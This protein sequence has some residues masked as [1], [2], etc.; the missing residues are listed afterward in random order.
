MS[1]HGITFDETMTG[2]FAMGEQEPRAGA[3]KGEAEDTRLV[4]HVKVAITDLEVFLADPEHTGQLTGII[5]FGPLG[6][7]INAD[8][9]VFNLFSPTD[10]PDARYM[11]YELAF[12][13]QGRPLYLAGRKIV[14]HDQPFDLW[15]DTTTLFTTLHKGNGTSGKIIGSGVLTLNLVEL[16]K[17]VS[18]MRVNGH[19]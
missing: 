9:G 16:V 14:F 13:H 18:T 4:M 7:D 3:R 8:T 5:H 6:Q 2:P 15:T 17:M 10:T 12:Q 19:R 1:T 11:I